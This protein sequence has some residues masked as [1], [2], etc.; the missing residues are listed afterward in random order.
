M[1]LLSC[2]IC[3]VAILEL[4]FQALYVQF[5]RHPFLFP[6]WDTYN[7]SSEI[8]NMFFINIFKFE[9]GYGR[10]YQHI[11][12]NYPLTQLNQLL[13]RAKGLYVEDHF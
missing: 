10:L 12:V 11:T 8:E 1:W 6:T 3:V 4:E 5:W 9:P 13:S 7:L 2:F